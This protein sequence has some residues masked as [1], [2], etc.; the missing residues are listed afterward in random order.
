LASP[1][2]FSIPT[3]R[4]VAAA[5]VLA[6]LTQEALATKAG[7]DVTTV[8]RMEAVGDQPIRSRPQN[9]EKL[10]RALYEASV[11]LH[12]DGVKLRR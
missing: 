11:E 10:L 3:G 12:P 4:M 9:I 2:F 1:P 5:R 8:A 6:G 7:L